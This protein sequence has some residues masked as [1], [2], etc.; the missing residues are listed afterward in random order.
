MSR[1]SGII[2]PEAAFPEN[3]KGVSFL[4]QTSIFQTLKGAGT[5]LLKWR[6]NERLVL[7]RR[8]NQERRDFQSAR[9]STV[10]KMHGALD[11]STGIVSRSVEIHVCIELQPRGPG[12]V[13]SAAVKKTS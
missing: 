6:R 5:K 9:K 10:D 13:N 4:I 8:S 7:A 3:R 1:N 2:S 11:Q 12:E